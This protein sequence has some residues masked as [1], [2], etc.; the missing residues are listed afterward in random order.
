MVKNEKFAFLLNQLI[1][2]QKLDIISKNQPSKSIK[3]GNT[4]ISPSL[5]LGKYS[6]TL[7]SAP[8]WDRKLILGMYIS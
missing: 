6:S 2:N 3:S 1:E 8:N 5:T 4:E 7:I